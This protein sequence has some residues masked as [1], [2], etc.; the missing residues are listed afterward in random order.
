MLLCRGTQNCGQLCLKLWR[1]SCLSLLNGGMAGVCRHDLHQ[2]RFYNKA[3]LGA[4]T[5]HGQLTRRTA[6]FTTSLRS[7][8]DPL[9]TPP[10]GPTSGGLQG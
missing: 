4:Q 3:C 1:S 7:L 6:G 9:L 10:D 5:E 8:S 2:L